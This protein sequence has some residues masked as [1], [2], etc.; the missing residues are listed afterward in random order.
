MV[1]LQYLGP[2]DTYAIPAGQ[3]GSG[4]EFAAYGAPQDVDA[5]TADALAALASHPTHPHR[6]VR[7]GKDEPPA[8][9]LASTEPSLPPHLA[10]DP[11]LLPPS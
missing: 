6:F 8:A 5:A 10:D 9:P 3:G 7:I 1:K 4:A 2:S 11:S